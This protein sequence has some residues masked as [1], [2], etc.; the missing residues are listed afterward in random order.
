MLNMPEG[1]AKGVVPPKV[2]MACALPQLK[3][4]VV[5]DP[6]ARGFY[7]RAKNFPPAFGG[8]D[9]VR[10]S[11]ACRKIAEEKITL[12]TSKLHDWAD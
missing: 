4:Q 5:S 12:V 1:M 6:A 2:L 8:A 3:S 7:V 9:R 10:L 11:A